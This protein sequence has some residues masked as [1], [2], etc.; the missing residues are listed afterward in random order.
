[1]QVLSLSELA[2][3]EGESGS[4]VNVQG[5]LKERDNLLATLESLKGL[6]IQMQVEEKGSS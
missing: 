6:I 4:Q 2:P 3:N 1:M 5:W